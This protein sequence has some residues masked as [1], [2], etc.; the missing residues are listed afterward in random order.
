[1]K[2]WA[3]SLAAIGSVL[4]ASLCCLP[5][6]PLALAAGGA[7]AAFLTASKLQPYLLGLSVLCVGYGFWQAARAK[8]CGV[9]R[10]TLN[11][12]L[13]AIAAL[14]TGATLLFPQAVANRFAPAVV[15]EGGPKTF[16]TIRDVAQLRQAFN[17][18]PAGAL[19]I[20]AFYSPT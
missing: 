12:S 14:M 16:D 1:M 4:A 2:S 13:L 10:K 6:L 3:S 20:V 18:S 8:Q 5:I 15:V 7:S 17:D 19:K 9:G 11:Y